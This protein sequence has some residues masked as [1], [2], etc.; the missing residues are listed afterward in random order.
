MSGFDLRISAVGGDRFATVPQ[1][2]P[3]LFCLTLDE[4]FD[5]ENYLVA[6]IY[7]DLVS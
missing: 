2:R 4:K 6:T 7:H 3:Y 5:N 1:P